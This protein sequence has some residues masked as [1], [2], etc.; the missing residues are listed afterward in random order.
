MFKFNKNSPFNNNN[1]IIIIIINFGPNMELVK[2]KKVLIFGINKA[3]LLN[4]E[5]FKNVIGIFSEGIA[6]CSSLIISFDNDKFLLFSHFNEDFDIFFEVKNIINK[7][8]GKI[9]EKFSE[10]YIFYSKG[11]GPLNNKSINHEEIIDKFNN[12]FNESYFNIN[13]KNIHLYV[14][15]HNNPISLLKIFSK[16]KED[17]L[18]IINL[19][20]QNL[21]KKKLKKIIMDI[22]KRMIF[23]LIF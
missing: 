20:F 14:K 18:N 4:T 19:T 5:K 13:K 12:F 17:F 1:I 8:I 10:I 3:H 16:N 2:E 6:T 21:K 7:E 11:F 23:I 9:G 22:K 15:E